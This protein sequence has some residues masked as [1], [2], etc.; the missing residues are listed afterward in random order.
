MNLNFNWRTFL[1]I[2]KYLSRILI[3]L[4][5]SVFIHFLAHLYKIYF[6]I[7]WVLF[8]YT[9]ISYLLNLFQ[10]PSCFKGSFKCYVVTYIRSGVQPK[11]YNFITIL[12]ELCHTL[13]LYFILAGLGLG[14]NL[15]FSENYSNSV[16]VVALC[17]CCWIPHAKYLIPD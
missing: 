16:V 7:K 11:Y 8:I 10:I 15:K 6:G 3:S 12:G 1:W 2:A 17:F 14:F 4:I 9:F 5:I 13:Y